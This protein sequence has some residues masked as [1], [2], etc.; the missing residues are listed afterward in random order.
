MY[1]KGAAHLFCRFP[2]RF[3]RICFSNICYSKRSKGKASI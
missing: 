2:R 3:E 1:Q